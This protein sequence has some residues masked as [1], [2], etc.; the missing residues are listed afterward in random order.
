MHFLTSYPASSASRSIRTHIQWFTFTSC[1]YALHVKK[2]QVSLYI[3]FMS[4]AAKWSSLYIIKVFMRSEISRLHTGQCVT[5]NAHFSHSRWCVHGNR[6]VLQS[7]SLHLMHL[8]IPFSRLF[9]SNGSVKDKQKTSVLQKIHTR[10]DNT[11]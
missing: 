4:K 1:T 6:R 9:S 7:F 11:L 2:I 3:I 8:R 10:G 5:S